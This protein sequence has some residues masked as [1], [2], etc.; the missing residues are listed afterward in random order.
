ME[1]N[2]FQRYSNLRTK[3]N[4]CLKRYTLTLNLLT[5]KNLH[6]MWEIIRSVLPHKSTRQPPLTLK[7]ND[8]ITDDS[9]SIANQF[10]KYTFAQSALTWQ[11]P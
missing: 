8:H 5:T 11:I 6:K 2:F 9:N 7:V 10:N 4:S 3:L 1:K